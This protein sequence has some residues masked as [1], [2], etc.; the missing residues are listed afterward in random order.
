MLYA[1]SSVLI[2]LW[3]FG[4]ATSY[5]AG[6][7]IHLCLVGAILATLIRVAHDRRSY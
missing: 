5:T 2:L 6:G 4:V 7:M 1:I 3:V